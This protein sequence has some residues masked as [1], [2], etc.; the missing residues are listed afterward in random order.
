M[1]T[2][3]QANLEN[4]EILQLYPISFFI[5]L[6]IMLSCFVGMFA[7]FKYYKKR[8]NTVIKTISLKHAI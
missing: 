8:S 4:V 7:Y 6:L 5:G 2:E 1:D 3:K